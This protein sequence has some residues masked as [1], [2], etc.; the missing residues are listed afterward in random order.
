MDEKY[1]QP[2]LNYLVDALQA[3]GVHLLVLLG[4]LIMLALIMHFLSS[5]LRL[6]GVEAFGERG[7]VYGFKMI[8]TPVHELGHVVFAL[9]FGHRVVSVKWFD[10]NGKGG[11]YGFVKTQYTRGNPFHETGLLFS[12]IGPV[13]MCALMLYAITWL[14]FGTAIHHL[15]AYETIP[16]IFHSVESLPILPLSIVKAV[17]EITALLFTNADYTW[18]KVVIFIYL[19]FA[20]GSSMTLSPPDIRLATKGF[21]FFAVLLFLFNIATLWAGGFLYTLFSKTASLI[22]GFLTVMVMALVIQLI[23]A[24]ILMVVVA[25]KKVIRG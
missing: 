3:T 11:A 18:W 19:F 13:L 4:P 5:G 14:L 21:L 16:N 8:G 22:S 20:I 6:L 9:I 7:F 25:I 23:F 17:K 12:G 15:F 24:V 10:P 1:L 2:A